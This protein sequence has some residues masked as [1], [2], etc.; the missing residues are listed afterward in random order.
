MYSMSL[1]EKLPTDFLLQLYS[2]LWKN[3]DRGIIT[4]NMYYELGLM[5]AA[6]AKRGI[7]LEE[8]FNFQESVDS[9]LQKSFKVDYNFFMKRK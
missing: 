6:S 1:Y 9:Q 8:P 5:V 3:I 4:K 7:S 2:E